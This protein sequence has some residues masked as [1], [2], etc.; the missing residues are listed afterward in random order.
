MMKNFADYGKNS[1]TVLENTGNPIK[2]I[3]YTKDRRTHMDID[4]DVKRK[5]SD[6]N[7]YVD[8]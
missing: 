1:D 3:I 2:R 4:S 6:S 5:G 8:D 7:M